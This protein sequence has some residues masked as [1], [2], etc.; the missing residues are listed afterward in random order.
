M[1]LD[2]LKAI[3]LLI[4]KIRG[5]RAY[6]F[7]DRTLRGV[8]HA[9]QALAIDDE[10]RTFHPNYW[11]DCSAEIDMEQVWFVGMHSNVGGSYP[12]DGLAY[13][14]LEWMIEEIRQLNL[15]LLL[16]QGH[17]DEVRNHANAHDK[18]YD[19]RSGFAVFYRYAPRNLRS[20]RWGTNSFWFRQFSKYNWFKDVSIMK[21]VNQP[22]PTIKVHQSVWRRIARGTGDYAPLFVHD[23]VTLAHTANSK[24][25]YSKRSLDEEFP[26]LSTQMPTPTASDIDE[27]EKDVRKKQ[28]S[29]LVFVSFTISLIIYLVSF[30]A[31]PVPVDTLGAQILK[32]LTPDLLSSF[33]DKLFSNATLSTLSLTILIGLYVYSIQLNKGITTKSRSAW[34]KAIS[35]HLP[36]MKSTTNTAQRDE[37]QKEREEQ[38]E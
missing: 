19:S 10:R 29:Y 4:W 11:L 16:P 24:S 17:I 35:R 36:C 2:E 21:Q 5:K 18:L 25:P 37:K 27:I 31:K 22:G 9:R 14:T 6:T 8:N 28:V 38:A 3:D 13:V 34:V 26:Q 7:N 23:D 20:I 15:G 1:P 12:K 30:V 32:Y 33:I